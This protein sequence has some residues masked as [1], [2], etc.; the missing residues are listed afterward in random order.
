VGRQRNDASAL[1][2]DGGRATR[3]GGAHKAFLSIDGEPIAARTLR[4][5]SELVSDVLVSTSRPDPWRALGLDVRFVED[6]MPGN[7]PLSGIA[8]ALA[9]C[10]TPWLL[11]VAGDMPH[12]SIALLERILDR[13]TTSDRPAA[14]VIG[15]RVEPLCAVYARRDAAAARDALAAGVRRPADFLASC[16]F[17][18]LTDED[19]RGLDVAR[20]LRNVNSPADL[21]GG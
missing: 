5:L 7:G 12:V 16:G 9:S 20:A 6:V 14:P 2:L 17:V 15:G 19:L 8:G 21:T 13:A 10:R 3:F 11:V 1:V 4:V 18:P